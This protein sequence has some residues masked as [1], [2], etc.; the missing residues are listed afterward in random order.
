MSKTAA[1]AFAPSHSLLHRLLAAID[2]GLMAWA[3]INI[4]N[5]DVPRFG[6]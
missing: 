2:R 6:L 5:G 1:V 3:E 4:R